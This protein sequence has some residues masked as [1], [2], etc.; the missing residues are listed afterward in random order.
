MKNSCKRFLLNVLHFL[1]ITLLATSSLAVT[2]DITTGSL[3]VKDGAYSIAGGEDISNPGNSYVIT[4]SGE[5]STANTITVQANVPAASIQLN[6]VDI[7]TSGLA[8][9]VQTGSNVTLILQDNSV[10]T[11]RSGSGP[12]IQIGGPVLQ[13]DSGGNRQF[14]CH[15]CLLS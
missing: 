4:Q 2:I 3:V 11:V 12:G 1:I 8:I 10:N 14:R 15:P 7:A 5:D 13:D 9:D 6:G